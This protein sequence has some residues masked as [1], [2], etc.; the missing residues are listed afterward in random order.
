MKLLTKF[1]EQAENEDRPINDITAPPPPKKNS[2]SLSVNSLYA[3]A[4][5]SPMNAVLMN[6]SPHTSDE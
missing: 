1:L 5:K 3:Y 6:M 4:K 2:I